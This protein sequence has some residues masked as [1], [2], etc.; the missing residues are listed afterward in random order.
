MDSRDTRLAKLDALSSKFACILLATAGLVR[1]GLGHR[2]TQRLDPEIFP[3]AVGQGALGIETSTDRH[4]ILD[5]VRHAD[6]RPS[7]WRGLAERAMLRTLQGGCSSPVGVYSTFVP[8]AEETETKG[9]LRFYNG[10]LCLHVTVLDIDGKGEVSAHRESIVVDDEGAEKLGVEV[11]AILSK[12]GA[13]N[14]LAKH[15]GVS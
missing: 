3:Y 9:A 7:R 12:E 15:T 8:N 14:L 10:T 1:L 6:H 4:D 11:A 13:Q 2:I 5:I